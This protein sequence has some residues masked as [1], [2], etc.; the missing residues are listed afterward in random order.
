MIVAIAAG[1]GKS[2]RSGAAKA[3]GRVTYKGQPLADATVTLVPQSGKGAGA[4]GLTD[5]SG[6]FRLT[7]SGGEGAFPGAYKVTVTKTEE[8][9]ASAAP[10]TADIEALQKA[11]LQG[12]KGAPKSASPPKSLVPS[13]YTTAAK[14]PL[15]CEVTQGGKNEFDFDLAD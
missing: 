13:K 12:L 11:D 1:C 8:A 10:K 4:A 3:S 6:R 15:S 5:E 14:T 7:T 2:V 9:A